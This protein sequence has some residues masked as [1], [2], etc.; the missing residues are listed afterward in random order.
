[1]NADLIRLIDNLCDRYERTF[2]TPNQPS[3]AELL[4]QVESEARGQLLSEILLLD[5]EL[6]P[7][8]QLPQRVDELVIAFPQY[9][10]IIREILEASTPWRRTEAENL[11]ASNSDRDSVVA[12]FAISVPLRPTSDPSEIP[13]VELGNLIGSGGMGDVYRGRQG[14]K[15]VAI[16]FLSRRYRHQQTIRDRF[17][18]EHETL[19]R[20]VHPNIV[21][22]FSVADD[23]S[24]FTM[25]LVDGKNLQEWRSLHAKELTSSLIAN[26]MLS[27]A[28]AVEY[29]NE[30]GVVHR[31]LKPRNVLITDG[32][33]QTPTPK[34]IDF[35][36]AAVAGAAQLTGTG[37]AVGSLDYMAPEALVGRS[38]SPALSVDV[39]G[40]GA[41]LYFLLSGRAPFDDQAA[42]Y[43]ELLRLLRD[44]TVVPSPPLN[45]GS[46]LDERLQHIC[47]KCL[48]TLEQRYASA[49]EVALEFQRY[50]DGNP[51]LASREGWS[52]KWSRAIRRNYRL[53][54]A[55]VLISATAIWMGWLWLDARSEREQAYRTVDALLEALDSQAELLQSSEILRSPQNHVLCDAIFEGYRRNHLGLDP[56]RL[57]AHRAKRHL[58]QLLRVAEVANRIGRLDDANDFLSYAEE[59]LPSVSGVLGSTS[60]GL[61]LATSIAVARGTNDLDAE[62]LDHAIEV[63]EKSLSQLASAGAKYTQSDRDSLLLQAKLHRIAGRA[64]YL[65]YRRGPEL[66]AMMRETLGELRCRQA[67]TELE[68]SDNALVELADAISFLGLGLYKSPPIN[69]EL[70]RTF[71]E[72]GF[73]TSHKRVLEKAL[74]VLDQLQNPESVDAVLCRCRIRNTLGLSIVRIDSTESMRLFQENLKQYESLRETYPLVM[75]YQIGVARSLGN[76]ADTSLTREQWNEDFEFRQRACDEYIGARDQ[77]GLQRDL[78]HDICLHSLRLYYNATYVTENAEVGRLARLRVE[79]HVNE[80]VWASDDMQGFESIVFLADQLAES[81][82]QTPNQAVRALF[83]SRIDK[84]FADLKRDASYR[85]FLQARLRKCT[86]VHKYAGERLSA[87]GIMIGDSQE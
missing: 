46:H 55:T 87:A 62:R 54:V 66:F 64:I 11:G 63:V 47:L 2:S 77:F 35:G 85:E 75:D 31:D 53:L 26:L 29:A 69:D 59:L 41:I 48:Q 6:L 37:E 52:A 34:L 7:S 15:P 71:G 36:V 58:R 16:K 38:S 24:Y 56:S 10:T 67:L 80:Q 18:R 19:G 30:R 76:L 84:M 32:S 40:L 50:L 13:D 42:N 8:H 17:H 9:E 51:L 1:M 25:E 22:V 43:H 5:R 86:S 14:G 28:R 72:Q 12:T 68:P 61:H 20:L 70:S 44:P 45:R 57:D 65:K 27:L 81:E 73:P 21:E 33:N 49:G 82:E 3:I 79:D 83:E 78:S 4:E 39:Y 23:G 60:D 74:Q